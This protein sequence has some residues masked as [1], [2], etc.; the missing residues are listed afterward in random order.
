VAVAL[1]DAGAN[2]D[3]ATPPH[4]VNCA[5]FTPLMY[6]VADN[7]AGVAKLLLKRG[8][9]GTKT[10]IEVFEGIDSWIDA[11]STALGI[12]RLH[13]DHDPDCTETFEVLRRRCCS[14]CGM[15]SP[16][17]A[18]MTAGEEQHLKRCGD[19]PAR[20]PR[21]RYCSKACQ[22]ADWVARHRGECAEARRARQV[23]ETTKV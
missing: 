16:G 9:D 11:G 5:G 12:A 23:A 8:A 6:A 3:F 21:A 2:V 7:H 18:A 13:A 1:L 19:C 20:S 17:L 22:R 14:T 15:T 4:H 10:T